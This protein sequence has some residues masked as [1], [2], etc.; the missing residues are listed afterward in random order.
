MDFFVLISK[1][2]N[3][4]ITKSKSKFVHFLFIAKFINQ[5]IFIVFAKN[6][7]LLFIPKMC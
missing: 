4:T 5:K 6:L 7:A 1:Y 3:L 2:F